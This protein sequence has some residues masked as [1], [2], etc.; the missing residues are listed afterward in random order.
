MLLST[1]LTVDAKVRDDWRSAHAQAWAWAC[2][3][4]LGATLRPGAR[5][6]PR[7]P[8]TLNWGAVGGV[9]AEEE[10]EEEE[11]KYAAGG[12]GLDALRPAGSRAATG[13][14]ICSQICRRQRNTHMQHVYVCAWVTCA[15]SHVHAGHLASMPHAHKFRHACRTR[16]TRSFPRR[17]SGRQPERLYCCQQRR[18]PHAH[19][20]S[21]S[22]VFRQFPTRSKP[23]LCC[24]KNGRYTRIS[25]YEH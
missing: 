14:R 25:K 19:G 16:R 9:A 24:Q 20:R 3:H 15:G 7:A 22:N 18:T 1:P 12:R 5:C 2:M 8:H 4:T 23:V 6:W 21:L 13:A 10:G 11:E 17:P